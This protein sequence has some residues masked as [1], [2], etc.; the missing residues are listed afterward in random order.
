MLF[1]HSLQQD[2]IQWLVINSISNVAA[3]LIPPLTHVC[4]MRI[5]LKKQTYSFTATLR[6]THRLQISASR[7]GMVETRHA[8]SLWEWGRGKT[9]RYRLLQKNVVC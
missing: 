6:A 3:V 1:R 5:A 2:F 4:N 7:C 9:K 8:R